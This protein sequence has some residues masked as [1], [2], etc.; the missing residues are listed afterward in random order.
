[1]RTAQ[2]M[3]TDDQP[4]HGVYCRRCTRL[5]P[6]AAVNYD[7]EVVVERFTTSRFRPADEVLDVIAWFC[8]DHCGQRND[9]TGWAARVLSVY[10]STVRSTYP[11]ELKAAS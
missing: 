1:M 7:P 5:S 10:W 2:D 9:I 11:C 6:M 4:S 3:Q 8:C